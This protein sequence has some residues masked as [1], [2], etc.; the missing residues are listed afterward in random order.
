VETIKMLG[1]AFDATGRLIAGV[2]SDQLDDRTPCS[3]W[4][5][6]GLINHTTG[7]VARMRFVAARAAAAPGIP[8]EDFVGKDPAPIFRRV[9][10]ATLAAW[11]EPGAL[12]GEC[13]LPNGAPAPA[14]VAAR[15][16]VVDTLVHGWDLAVATG[17]DPSIDP[18]LAAAALEF[19]KQFVSDELR[20]PGG[21]FR[22]AV[23]PPAGASPTTELVAFLGREP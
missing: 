4:D 14:D 10:S 22:A 17:Q 7:V 15:V 13:V 2:S 12:D 21:P 3:D 1:G 11:S 18:A 16:N 8:D 19:S 20:Q 9:A 23:A 5:V 6:R